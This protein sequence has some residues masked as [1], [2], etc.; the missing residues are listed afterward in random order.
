MS[1]FT[2]KAIIDSFLKLLNEK[3]FDKI[4]VKSIVEDCGVNRKTF[5]YYFEDIYDLAEQ[6]FENEIKNLSQLMS[7]DM[8][9]GD[10]VDLLCDMVENNRHIITHSFFV[11]GEVEMRRLFYNVLCPT[12]EN[13][14]RSSVKDN[15]VSEEDIETVGRI[16]TFGVIGSAVSWITSGFDPDEKERLKK[17]CVLLQG[18]I[19][20]MLS[21]IQE[22]NN[23]SN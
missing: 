18:S 2:K 7:P 17:V 11:A 3:S 23:A 21:N 1:Q 20:I 4:T 5:Y 22:Y 13:R 12:F 8:N 19:P 16:I 14:V 9:V 15:S 10:A 6:I